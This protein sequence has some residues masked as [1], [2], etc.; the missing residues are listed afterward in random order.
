MDKYFSAAVVTATLLLPGSDFECIII[1]RIW[2]YDEGVE[3][4]LH[5]A[6]VGGTTP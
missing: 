5:A 3:S 1:D 4:A 2:A 6:L